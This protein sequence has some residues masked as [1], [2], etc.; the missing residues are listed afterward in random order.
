MATYEHF[1]LGDVVSVQAGL[2][3]PSG[4]GFSICNQHGRPLLSITYPTAVEA[5]AAH[6]AIAEALA[7]ASAVGTPGP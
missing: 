3:G 1:K 6:T 5:K 2:T 4:Y 7:N